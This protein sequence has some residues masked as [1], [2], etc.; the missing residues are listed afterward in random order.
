MEAL[1][2]ESIVDDH[3]MERPCDAVDVATCE[4]VA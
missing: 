1:V 3:E 4:S 2:V